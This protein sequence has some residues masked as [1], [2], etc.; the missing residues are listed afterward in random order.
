M[1]KSYEIHS[2]ESNSHFIP[3]GL[4]D[5]IIG[6]DRFCGHFCI[7][8][9]KIGLRRRKSNLFDNFLVC[10][11]ASTPHNFGIIFSIAQLGLFRPIALIQS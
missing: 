3:P 7:L 4:K 6:D 10:F 8:L 11:A 5:L 1:D 9:S 2:F